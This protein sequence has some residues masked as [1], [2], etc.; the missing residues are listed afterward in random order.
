ML[1][2]STFGGVLLACLCLGAC[3]DDEPANVAGTYTLNIANGQNGC[4]F[5]GFGSG[6]RGSNVSLAMVQDGRDVSGTVGGVAGNLLSALLGSNSFQGDVDESRVHMEIEGNRA[7]SEGN[8]AFTVNA[9]LKAFADGDFLEGNI[10]YTRVDNGN[11]D[12]AALRNCV[13]VQSFNGARPP[14]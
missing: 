6:V 5:S 4:N 8:C 10:E 3:G 14:R 7:G 12:C 1:K 2:V 11:S 9:T 13:S